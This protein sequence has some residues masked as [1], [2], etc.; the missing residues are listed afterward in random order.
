MISSCWGS[1][2]RPAVNRR[3]TFYLL[4]AGTDSKIDNIIKHILLCDKR[5]NLKNMFKATNNRKSK[6]FIGRQAKISSSMKLALP[7]EGTRF[8]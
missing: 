3:D 4:Y 7:L 2:T 6:A 8:P 5:K 1:I